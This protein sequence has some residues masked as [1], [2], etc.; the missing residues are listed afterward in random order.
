MSSHRQ[1]WHPPLPTMH[2]HKTVPHL[3]WL[4]A[5][6][7]VLCCG[8]VHPL[9]QSAC[10]QGCLSAVSHQGV[11]SMQAQEMERFRKCSTWLIW[12]T[13]AQIC[14]HMRQLLHR[15][16]QATHTM[17]RLCSITHDVFENYLWCLSTMSGSLTFAFSCSFSCSRLRILCC[18][19]SSASIYWGVDASSAP[20]CRAT[21]TEYWRGSQNVCSA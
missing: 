18:R 9:F 19:G 12:Y 16:L 4:S 1:P 6:R 3:A 15:V 21:A 14:F 11:V 17:T 13:S 7:S 10:T 5:H 8:R 20:S 2:L